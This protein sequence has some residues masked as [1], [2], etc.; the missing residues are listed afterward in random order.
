MESTES[1][2]FSRIHIQDLSL[3]VF[4][5]CTDEERSVRQAVSVSV[6]IDFHKPP[7]A[8]RS[9]QLSDTVCYADICDWLK[10]HVSDRQFHLVEKLSY[11]FYTLIKERLHRRALVKVHTHKVNPPIA[12]L[13]G[14]VVYECGDRIL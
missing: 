4:L 2:H 12:D 5:G 11:D 9:D 14:G 6:T 8:E 1:A 3:Q 13:E 10:E 7:Y